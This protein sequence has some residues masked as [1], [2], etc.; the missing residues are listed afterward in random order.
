MLKKLIWSYGSESAMLSAGFS[1]VGTVVTAMFGEVDSVLKMLFF[2][3]VLDFVTGILVAIK[4]KNLNSKCMLWGGV[5][6]I[7]VLCMVATGTLLDGMLMPEGD[8][9]RVAVMYFFISR[10]L[11]SITENYGNLGLPLPPVITDTLG[12]IVG[13]KGTAKNDDDEN[14]DNNDNSL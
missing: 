5:N 10:E 9:V 1:V 6:K 2:L 4:Q 3:I 8:Y 14:D 12:Q 7:L 11:L 13:S